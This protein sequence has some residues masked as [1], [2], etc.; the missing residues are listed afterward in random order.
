MDTG[1]KPDIVDAVLED[2]EEVRSLFTKFEASRPDHRGELWQVIVRALAVH[3]TAEEE[4]VHPAVRRH[5]DG[6]DDIVVAR[7]RE[8]DEAKKALA[9]LER[10][11]P[12][13]SDFPTRFAAF[14]HDVL[15]HAEQEEQTELAEL[16]EL[17]DPEE[18]Q[19]MGALFFVA[20]SVAPTHAHKA[21]PESALGN[22]VVG[23]FVAIVDRVR[24]TIRDAM[25]K[26]AP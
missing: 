1:R 26:R 7:L 15:S 21:A 11:G 24:D 16:R 13:H 17:V 4:I 22:I 9:D 18:R 25:A 14:R 2:H 23:P 3:E 6:G 12:D 8:E 5:V 19:K 10:L 20:K